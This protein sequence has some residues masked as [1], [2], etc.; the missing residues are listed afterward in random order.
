MAVGEDAWRSTKQWA[1]DFLGDLLANKREMNEEAREE[2]ENTLARVW[3]L[4]E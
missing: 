1:K 2:I 3:N 4:P